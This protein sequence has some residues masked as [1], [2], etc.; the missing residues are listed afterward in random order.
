M[1]FRHLK[2]GTLKEVA[3]AVRASLDRAEQEILAS[4]AI[5]SFGVYDLEKESFLHKGL[6]SQEASAKAKLLN[7]AAKKTDKA[8]GRSRGAGNKFEVRE[9]EEVQPDD[10]EALP[11]KV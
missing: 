8:R 11:G 4:S 3:A 5:P 6:S 10:V 2:S 7:D 9:I 1:A